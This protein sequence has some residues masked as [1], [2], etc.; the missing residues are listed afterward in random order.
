MFVHPEP[1]Y[2]Y[3]R[4]ALL[5]AAASMGLLAA[6]GSTAERGLRGFTAA[7]TAAHLELERT[8]RALP[9]A[10]NI[11]GYMRVMSAEPHYAGHP[12]SRKVAEYILGQFIAW[13]LDA[14]IEETEALMPYPVERHLELVV[15]DRFTAKLEEPSLAEDPDSADAGQIPTFN[16]YAADGDVTADLVYVNYGTPEDYDR[17]ATLGVSVSGRI[18][19]A[20]YGRSWRG[21]KPKVAAEHGAVGCIIYSDPRDD[22]FYQGD[23][24]PTGPYRPWQGVQRGS[25]L[26]MPIHPGDPLTPGWGSARGGRKLSRSE[27]VTLPVIPVLPISY[28]DAL[29][30]LEAIGGVMAPE[31]WRGSLPLPYHVGPGP[32]RV[33][34]ALSFD[35]QVRPLY[36]VIARIAGRTNPDQWILYGN[37][38]D[39]WANGASDPTSG[40]AVLM[41]TAR[42]LGELRRR[43]WAPRRTI[44]FA[45]WDGEEWGLL[46]STEWAETHAEELR[47]N[48]VAYINTDSTGRGI[49]SAGGSHVL[50][51][52][53]GE[54]AADIVDPATGG[55]LLERQGAHRAERA[56]TDADRKKALDQ[57]TLRLE[58]L[59]S[60]S[61]YTPFLQHLSIASLN[62][63]FGGEGG[64]GV[65]HSIYDS[66]AWYEKFSD[67]DF[68]YCRTLA[69]FIGTLILR[70]SEATTL[71]FDFTRMAETVD[72]YVDELAA[73]AKRRQ[74]VLDLSP[75]RASIGRVRTAG[76]AYDEALERVLRGSAVASATDALSDLNR[77][78]YTSER[79]LAHPPGLPRRSWFKHLLYAPGLYTGY[80]VKTLPGI[81]EG[82][83]DGHLDE[84]RQFVSII[85]ASLDRLAIRV[86]EAT[87]RLQN[88]AE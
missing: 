14:S 52:F 54:V 66:V 77:L 45:S 9:R 3:R 88:L 31:D 37:H 49:L 62:F 24:Y 41:E 48:A 47:R 11:R 82:L 25:V 71:P 28:D 73:D 50:E 12:N 64:G 23:V 84:A 27:A 58:A 7:E 17:L 72:G 8:F 55:S 79:E 46:G 33:R 81:R 42:S 6:G 20:R 2:P 59:G 39:A 40:N 16:A 86:D 61:D 43:G 63:G 29:P 19:I 76:K 65:Y 38:H 67:T 30:L 80:G 34:L 60:G 74:V 57:K 4:L 15:P 87:E 10:E 83:E 56:K 22:G 32:A 21:I 1:R 36:N 53:V 69:Q 35:W 44:V 68:A 13:G 18:V 75:L 5:A 85:G 51:R 70:M 78:L 26:D